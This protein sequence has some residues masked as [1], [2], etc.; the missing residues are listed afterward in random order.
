MADGSAQNDSFLSRILQGITGAVAQKPRAA[1]WMVLVLSCVSIGATVAFVRFKTERSDLVSED[2]PVQQAWAEYKQY[3]GEASDIVVVVEGDNPATIRNIMD[4]MADRLQREPKLFANV[5]HKIDASQMQAKAL[6]FLTQNELNKATRQART[7]GGILRRGD[8]RTVQLDNY[9]SILDREINNRISK[10][11]KPDAVLLQTRLLTRSLN[12]FYRRAADDFNVDIDTFQTPWPPSVQVDQ[13]VSAQSSDQVYLMNEEGTLGFVKV[14]AVDQESEFTGATCCIERL[15]EHVAD[16]NAEYKDS[17]SIR[18][19]LTGIP[20][21]ENDEMVRSQSDMI[22][23]CGLALLAVG[24]LLF[25][26]FRGIRHP[27]LCLLMLVI[28]MPWTFGFTTAAIGHF[29]ILSVSF[30]VILIGLGIDFSIHYLSRYLQLRHEGEGL[31]HALVNTS[32]SVGT[33]IVTAAITTALAFLCAIA[34][35]FSGVAELGLIAGVGVLLCA[36]ATFVVLPAL[37]RLS[38]AGVPEAKLPTP[39]QGNGLRSIIN[40]WPTVV[41]VFSLLIIGGVVSQ[42]FDYSSG[43]PTLRVGY[44]SNLL[45]L[46][47][48]DSES[49]QMQNRIERTSRDS[50]LYA[51]SLANSGPEALQRKL[52]F[53][54]LPSVDRV[55]ELASKLPP[56]PTPSQQQQISSLRSQLSGLPPEVP[57]VFGNA[58]PKRVGKALDDLYMTVDRLSTPLARSV[59][60]DLDTFLNNFMELP[61]QGQIALLNAY[62]NYMASSLL[63][64]YQTMANATSLEPVRYADLPAELSSRFFYQDEEGNEKWVLKIYPTENIWDEAP[65]T[66]FVEDVRS[67]DASVTGAPLQNYEAAVSIKSSYKTTAMYAIAIISL[68][69]LFDFLKPGQKLLTLLPPIAIVG[70]VGYTLHQRNG[71]INPHMLVITYLVMVGFIGAVLDFRNLRD[72]FLSMLPPLAGGA[73]MIG[74]MAMLKMNLNPANLIVLPLVLGIGVDDGV[75]VMHDY[76]R[77]MKAGLKEYKISASTINAILLTSLTSMVGFGSLMIASHQGLFTVGLT[78]LIG[79]GCCGFISLIPLPAIL[80]LVGSS[81]A[82]EATISI[83]ESARQRKKRE[84]AAAAAEAADSEEEEADAPEPRRRKRRAA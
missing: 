21:L 10:A 77:Q 29:N 22:K 69:L 26:G 35:D 83:P 54:A 2:H 81:F 68:V 12:H 60:R 20:I 47:G 42:A 17:E 30:A 13:Y 14:F 9:A 36:A 18:V 44:D 33:G 23:G 66:K 34:T 50:L 19:A 84:K 59:Q 56:Q 52:E 27:M 31:Y 25:I 82:E 32:G 64:Q 6:Q 24:T 76:R 65:L 57:N 1:L 62:Q 58:D 63:R 41:V 16:V 55:E 61:L 43:S 51:V 5:L 49:V 74:T 45:R 3:F 48:S 73:M 79:V 80:R 37:I 28:A 75:H 53:E 11:Q 72:M 39:I 8:W 71:T 67:V 15:R 46:Q 78:L 7:Y 70:F 4:D 38:D 40:G